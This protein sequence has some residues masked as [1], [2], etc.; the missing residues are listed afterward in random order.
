MIAKQPLP[1]WIP[2]L[3]AGLQLLIGGLRFSDGRTLLAI[4]Q[5]QGL[6]AE[7][8]SN[9][10]THYV[11]ESPLKV[12]LLR[13]WPLASLPALAALFLLLG[14]LPL[15]GLLWPRSSRFYALSA[16]LLLLTPAL[17]VSLQNLGVGDGLVSL[18]S[19]LL[20]LQRRHTGRAAGL[21]LLIAAWHPGQAPFIAI[22]TLVGM[23]ACGEAQPIRRL[24]SLAIAMAATLLAGRLLLKL[25]NHSLGFTYTDRFGY[26]KLRLA[27]FLPGNLLHAPLALLFP[28]SLCLACWLLIRLPKQRLGS[29]LILAWSAVVSAVALLTTD[30]SRVAVLCLTPLALILAES[31]SLHR[32][33]PWLQHFWPLLCLLAIALIPLYSWSGIDLSLWPDLLDDACKYGVTCPS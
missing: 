6:E 24:W 2:L 28:I 12:W 14:L 33:W 26:L 20:V 22:S 32:P 4:A 19:V 31:T 21:L 30:V 15:T 7:I 17:K 18:L 27:E 23:L 1:R 5:G 13:A 29:G 16:W 8:F 10:A 3:A 11:W 9:P 25:H